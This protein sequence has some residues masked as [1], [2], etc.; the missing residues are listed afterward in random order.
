MQDFL[1]DFLIIEFVPWSNTGNKRN[2]NFFVL[3]VI[4]LLNQLSNLTGK[5]SRLLETVQS[6]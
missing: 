4:I 3:L 2:N 1:T 5:E 6:H